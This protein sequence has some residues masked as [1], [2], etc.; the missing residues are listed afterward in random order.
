MRAKCPKCVDGCVGCDGGYV[1]LSV[2]EGEWYTRHCTN[3]ECGF[4]NGACHED[5]LD[6]ELG[7]CV[8]C[9]KGGVEWMLLSESDQENAAWRNRQLNSFGRYLLDLE[10]L[11]RDVRCC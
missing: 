11:L 6:D 2:A 7:C 3:E 8:M 9:G 10:C 5:F 4:D 1:E